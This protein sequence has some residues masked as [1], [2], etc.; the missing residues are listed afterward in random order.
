MPGWDAAQLRDRLHALEAAGGLA[1]WAGDMSAANRHYTQ[2][3]AAAREAGDEAE[4]ANALYNNFF[5]TRMGY[6]GVGDWVASLAYEG[7]PLLDEAIAIW[8]RLGDEEGL[9]KGLW[10]LGEHHAYRREYP[11]SIDASTRALAIFERS[12]SGFWIAWS[13]FTRGFAYAAQRDVR[14][15]CVDLAVALREFQATRDISG[16]ALVLSAS[17]SAMLMAGWTAEGYALGGASHRAIAETGLH[18][19]ALWPDTIFPIPDLETADPTLR[20]AIA[21]GEGWSREESVE[22]ALTA[23]DMVAAGSLGPDHEA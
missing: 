10:A 4:L 14:P 8:E 16:V 11:E 2:A 21:K 9:A 18:L 5:A 1:Y 20:A 12:G 3:V 23:I 6:A 7:R 13:R 15:A 17:S 19:A 22:R